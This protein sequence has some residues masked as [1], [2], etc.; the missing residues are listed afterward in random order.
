MNKLTD[1]QERFVQEYMIDLNATQAAIRAGYS[2]KTAKEQG[3]RLF[4]NVHI[5][6]AI[7]E[8]QKRVSEKLELNAEWVIQR[9]KENYEKAMEAV[10]VKDKDGNTIGEFTY[11]G[12][13]AN[14]SL[15]LIGKQ[16]GM[17]KERVESEI[18]INNLKGISN[19]QLFSELADR[20]TSERGVKPKVSLRELGGRLI[21]N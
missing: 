4:T 19:E 14:K 10:P 18:N 7:Q 8:K 11:N 9:L 16:I 2:V 20:G 12:S 6:A 21:E 1:K 15:E 3:C 17:F 13:V 5:Q